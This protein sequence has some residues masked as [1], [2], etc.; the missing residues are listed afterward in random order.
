MFSY[1][2]IGTSSM[3]YELTKFIV[4]YLLVMYREHSHILLFFPFPNSCS[5]FLIVI[6]YVQICKSLEGLSHKSWENLLLKERKVSTTN[7]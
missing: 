2:N 3:S 6:S 7:K 1:I 5:I 4:P